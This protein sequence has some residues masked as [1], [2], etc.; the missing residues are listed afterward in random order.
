MVEL[1]YSSGSLSFRAGQHITDT[2]ETYP[3]HVRRHSADDTN[4]SRHGTLLTAGATS[5]RNASELKAILGNSNAR[6]KT[7]SIVPPSSART[8]YAE[9]TYLEQA[10]P[11]ARVEVDVILDSQTIVEGGH[12]LGRIKVRIRKRTKKENPVLIASGKIRVIGFECI[13]NQD[14]RH[15]FFQAS[16]ML[17]DLA[18][19][20]KAMLGS[21]PDS[22]GFA[23]AKEGVYVFPFAMELPLEGCDGRPKG[24]LPLGSASSVR[25]IA[26]FSLKV[27]E[28]VTGKRSIAHFYRDCE[29]WPRFNPSLILASAPTPIR[30]VAT[31]S[32]FMGGSGKA[33]IEASIHRMFW[34]AGQRC[35]VKA[36][37]TNYTKKMV[38]SL[39]IT[40]TRKTVVFKPK[41]VLNIAADGDIDPDACETSTSE[42]IVAESTLAMGQ[43]GARGHA[44]AKGW[45]T[46]VHPG[47]DQE[48]M[49]FVQIPP[50]ALTIPRT[51]L[52]EV[53][54]Y[55]SVSISGGSLGSDVSVVL[56][57][58]IFNFLS[59][60][61][62]PTL[63]V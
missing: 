48:V 18:T 46:G 53:E 16:A 10:K 14:N 1:D 60:D 11:R 30:N 41:A 32:L 12:V 7:K 47:E 2:E 52:L 37:I 34:T 15:T 8:S 40:V 22:E 55:L 29:I 54:Y 4:L 23:L 38:R 13:G 63:P 24:V 9:K 25:Y 49:H 27:K 36:Y 51:R 35:W 44:S 5:S 56:P 31:K 26:M 45:W 62:P 58:K 28:H 19:D 21:A 61:P 3:S 59:I 43:R 57:I 42:R 17:E 39:T 33:T 50:E 6:L 20:H